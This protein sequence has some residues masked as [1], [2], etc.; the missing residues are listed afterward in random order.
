MR[1]L[2]YETRQSAAFVFKNRLCLE[3]TEHNLPPHP[4]F[5]APTLALATVANVS[6][7]LE[8][9]R[10]GRRGLGREWGRGGGKETVQ[11]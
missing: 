9:K 7:E 5:L 1:G 8:R 4:T 3:M 6:V 10:A 11:K 2:M